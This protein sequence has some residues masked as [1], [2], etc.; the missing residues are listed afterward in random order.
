MTSSSHPASRNNNAL[1]PILFALLFVLVLAV[2]HPVVHNEFL[3]WD[4][5]FDIR[6]NPHLGGL[7]WSN[8][9]WFFTNTDYLARYQ[10]LCWLVWAALRQFFG[11]GPFS[12]HA[13]LLLF[14]AANAG[15]VFLLVRRL[16]LLARTA[17]DDRTV[18]ICAALASAL[19]AVHPLRAET[20]AWAAALTYVQPLFFFLLSLLFYLRTG[21]PSAGRRNYWI[22]FVLFI[23]SLLSYPLAMGGLAVYLALDVFPLRRL[24]LDP[25]KWRS[26]A[27]RR[28]WMEKTPFFIAT[29]LCAWVNFHAR[30]QS[31]NFTPAPTLEQFGVTDRVMQAFYVWALPLWKPWLPL[32]LTPMRPE[33][34]SFQPFAVPFV[35]SALLVVGLTCFLWWR[36]TRWTGLFMLWL[37]HLALLVPALGLTEHPH[38]PADRYS[39]L[40]NIGW[41]IVLAT[42]FLKCWSDTPARRFVCSAVAV[43]VLVLSVMSWRQTAVW[44]TNDAFFHALLERLPNGPQFAAHRSGLFIRL[45]GTYRD[46]RDFP[47]AETNFQAAID[48]FPESGPT[49]DELARTFI[50]AGDFDAARASLRQAQERYPAMPLAWN[51]VGV[52]Y[53]RSSNYT[54]AVEMFSNALDAGPN[55][56]VALQ[57]MANAL[58]L[59]GKT[60]AAAG[61]L[62]KLDDLKNRAQPAR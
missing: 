2:F 13:I 9:Q 39:M 34:I 24:D 55:D 47:A 21:D 3:N 61:Y 43:V 60:N 31:V 40:V 8:F 51:D 50:L 22:S 14:H 36:Q 48:E 58:T 30:V 26:P 49:H 10:P 4:D 41:A 23:I 62:Q 52:A 11:P 17:R 16:L 45:A 54:A 59:L 29:I 25:V 57:N 27:Q 6:L 1:V 46:R 37:C 19:W 38:Y 53:A 7:A 20:T 28:V 35:L 42:L 12:A 44:R 33:L 5:D 56:P 32:D 18:S 15:L